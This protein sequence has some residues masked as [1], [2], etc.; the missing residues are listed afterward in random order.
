M[1]EEVSVSGSASFVLFVGNADDGEDV[2]GVGE[3]TV[4]SCDSVDVDDV[5]MLLGFG[6]TR[7]LVVELVLFSVDAPFD[8]NIA[9]KSFTLG[10]CAT[11]SSSMMVGDVQWCEA[12][13][14]RPGLV[15]WAYVIDARPSCN[16]FLSR[17]WPLRRCGRNVFRMCD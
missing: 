16:T 17:L 3:A 12:R 11:V 14:K 15:V 2:D 9:R 8:S 5:R 6:R 13:H 10:G 4:A 1:G 7:G